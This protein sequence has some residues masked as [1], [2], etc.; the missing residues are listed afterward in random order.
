MKK[1]ALLLLTF[2]F[3]SC[4]TIAR[5]E[6]SADVL[7]L[8]NALRDRNLYEI[9][10]RIDKNSL[11]YQALNIARE[12]LIEEASQRIGHGLGGQIAAVAAVDLLNPVIESLA[13]RVV[14]PDAIAFFARQAGL[15]QQTAMPSRME[16]TIAIRPIDNNRV[17]IPNPQNNR[18]VLYFNKFPDRWKLVAIDEAELRAKIRALSRPNIR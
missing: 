6:A 7:A 18:C 15:Q 14:E 13:E 3:A 16:T 17:C 1:I 5:H 8:V 2:T 12:I 11:K 10:A 4:A 9:E